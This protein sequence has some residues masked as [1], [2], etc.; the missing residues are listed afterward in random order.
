M[1]LEKIEHCH[2]SNTEIDDMV[3]DQMPWLGL[4]HLIGL[5]SMEILHDMM[6]E[7]LR[8]PKGL[9]TPNNEGTFFSDE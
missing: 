2:P 3:V 1:V 4:S 7:S 5:P 6:T 8:R 9:V